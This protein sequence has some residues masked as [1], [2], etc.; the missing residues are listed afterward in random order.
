MLD[1]FNLPFT[2]NVEIYLSNGG[3]AGFQI[4]NK[5]KRARLVYFYV[6][7]A[8]GG[9]GGGRSSAMN[10][11]TGGGGGGSGA[12]TT[13]LIS[14]NLLPDA[15]YMSPGVPGAGSL[16]S[17]VGGDGG[18]PSYVMFTPNFSATINTFLIANGGSGGNTGTGS[19]AGQGGAG[20]TIWNYQSTI[21]GNIGLITAD[22]GSAGTIGTTLAGTIVNLTP[23]LPVSGGSGGGAVSSGGTSYNGASIIGSGFLPTLA[24]GT[25]NST[26]AA[27]T[28]GKDGYNSLFEKHDPMFFTGGSGGGANATG[29]N[30]NGGNGGDGAPGC[31]GGGGA[32]TYNGTGGTGGRG[33]S[34]LILV[35]WI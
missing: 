1:L 2:N 23:T 26:N 20:G 6:L 35:S 30:A 21:H 18:L 28:R 3:N 32:G 29:I 16:A 7:G 8:G 27:V 33:G 17:S 34:G 24:P 31:G 15:L 4:W 5:P 9:G 19:V 11:S 13:A 22:A 14:A 10:S 12:I 25:N